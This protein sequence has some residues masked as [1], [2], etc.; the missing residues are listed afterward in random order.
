MHQRSPIPHGLP[1]VAIVG[2]ASQLNSVV[3]GTDELGLIGT[4][5]RASIQTPHRMTTRIFQVLLAATRG[6]PV[7]HMFVSQTQVNRL[8]VA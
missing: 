5:M 7:N 8:P 6:R 3:D 2:A 1:A 4:A